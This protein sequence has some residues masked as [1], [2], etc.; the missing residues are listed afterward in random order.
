[1][2][3][4]Y[5]TERDATSLTTGTSDLGSAAHFFAVNVEYPGH[6][7]LDVRDGRSTNAVSMML[8]LYVR[9]ERLAGCWRPAPCPPSP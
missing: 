1:V 8:H 2:R 7:P 6:G 4:Y 9:A 5:S 3:G